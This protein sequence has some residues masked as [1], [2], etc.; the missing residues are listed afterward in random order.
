MWEG[1]KRKKAALFGRGLLEN[2]ADLADQ[3][4]R[5]TWRSPSSSQE[6]RRKAARRLVRFEIMRRA[7]TESGRVRQDASFEDERAAANF[8]EILGMVRSVGALAQNS[9]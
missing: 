7:H 8:T 3:R 1:P 2:Q 9:R 4:R 5:R 6:R